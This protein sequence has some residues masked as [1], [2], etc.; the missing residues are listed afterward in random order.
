MIPLPKNWFLRLIFLLVTLAFLAFAVMQAI[1]YGRDH[2]NPQVLDEPAWDSPQTRAL[3]KKACFDCHSNETKWP[4]YSNIAPVSWLVYND[5]KGGRETL[6]FS[7]WGRGQES[8]DLVEVVL[9]REMPPGKY[10][11]LHPSA[12]LSAAE[13]EHLANGLA[14][15]QGTAPGG[16]SDD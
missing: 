9:E 14:T 5:V 2:K 15:I 4:W 13:R 16:E 10:T 1:P 6:N 8:D 11:I 12:K 3:A 7:E